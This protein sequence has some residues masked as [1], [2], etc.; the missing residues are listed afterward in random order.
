[1]FRR[2]PPR[3]FARR[4]PGAG[5]VEAKG[6]KAL[7]L[8]HRLME[9]GQYAQAFPVFKRLADGAA[10]R[11]LLLR[12]APL[13]FQAA[14]AR[15]EMGGAQDAVELARCGIQVL[16]QAGQIERIRTVLPRLTRALEVKGFYN[17]A[18][19]LRAETAALLGGERRVD[20]P[21][22]RRGTLPGK[23]P[24]CNGPVRSDEVTWIDENHAECVY[25]G[26]VIDTD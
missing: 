16:V 20:P 19:F 17:E 25:C 5:S 21:V 10:Q 13:Y 18:V 23:C 15:L 2:R 3:R 11:G 9:S 12:A 8:A 22:I 7:R 14:H 1:M 26:S 24:S 6:M 4:R